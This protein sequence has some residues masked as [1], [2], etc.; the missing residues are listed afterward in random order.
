MLLCLVSGGGS[1]LLTSPAG[2]LSLDD[3]RATTAALL[4]SGAPIEEVNAV[5]KHLEELKGGRL[6]ALAAPARV[7]AL[8]VSDVVGDPLDVIAS[9]PTAFDASTFDGASAVLRARGLWDRVPRAVTAHLEAGA[10]GAIAET[11]RADDPL[12]A[13]VHNVVVASPALAA[14]AAARRAS[15]LGW[16]AE[17]FDRHVTGEAR[18]VGAALAARALAARDRAPLALIGAGETTVTLRGDGFGGRNTEVALAASIA[19]E[20]HAGVAVASLATD[21]DDGP[22]GA[23]G[24][25]ATGGTVAGPRAR[26]RRGGRPRAQRQRS[27]LRASRG[28]LV[29][30]PTL[31][32]VADLY[33]LLVAR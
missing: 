19:L 1:A 18:G 9:G 5:R 14:E 28:L 8:I 11:P 13:R 2:G 33:C 20:G 31:T 7:V 17:V 27:V 21:G 32:N 22:T 15:E 23:A 24:A 16:R 3:L 25:V 30:G 12:F 26:R 6:A 4:A 10:R 29:T